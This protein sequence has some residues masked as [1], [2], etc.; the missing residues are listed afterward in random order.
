MEGENLTVAQLDE[1]IERLQEAE[2]WAKGDEA[3][4]KR[5]TELEEWR[6]A[7]GRQASAPGPTY[8]FR[9]VRGMGREDLQ[10][11]I[12]SLM[13]VGT[14]WDNPKDPDH[15]R[16]MQRLEELHRALYPIETP[17]TKRLEGEKFKREVEAREQRNFERDREQV[18]RRSEDQLKLEWGK[19]YDKN[20]SLAKAVLEQFGTEEDVDFLE[21]TGAGDDPELI[22]LL[23]RLG[24]KLQSAG[25]GYKLQR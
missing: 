20:L 8:G 16:V 7:R 13:R 17:A 12:K 25:K 9:P 10:H 15:G 14:A 5:L 4:M 3:G 22:R 1:E 21:A 24:E 11:E 19:D 6:D 23:H 2:P 18:A